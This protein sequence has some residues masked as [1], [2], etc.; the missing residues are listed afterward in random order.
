MWLLAESMTEK[1]GMPIS[2]DIL[3]RRTTRFVLWSPQP[4]NTAP[5]LV[6]GRLRN[7]NPPAVEG[8]RYIALAPTADAAGL[9]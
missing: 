4:Q 8:I 9:V 5:E 1:D 6:I 2:T 3:N 7:G